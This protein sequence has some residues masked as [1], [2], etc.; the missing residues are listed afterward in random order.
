[1]ALQ[2][3]T[4]DV[5][6][7]HI[8]SQ[9]KGF[10][11]NDEYA[12]NRIFKEEFILDTVNWDKYYNDFDSTIS[13]NNIS[14]NWNEFKY[15]DVIATPA[16]LDR[17]ITSSETGIYLFV[18]K[19]H[20]Q[21]YEYS[22]FVFYVGISGENGSGRPLRDRLKDYFRLEQIKKRNAVLRILEKYINNVHI[23][24]FLTNVN[25]TVL[26]Q[27]ETSLIGYFYPLANKDDFPVELQPIKKSF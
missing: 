14:L 24:F 4:V 9:N 23:A 21:I 15:T 1:M 5:L 13:S 27:I 17:I 26:K 6:D 3:K 2:K 12:R 18:V 11:K 19:S 22:K 16:L 7:A 25:Y 20:G 8:T 10:I